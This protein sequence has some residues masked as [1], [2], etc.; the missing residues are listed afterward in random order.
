MIYKDRKRYL[1]NGYVVVEYPEHE[2]A[3]DTGTGFFGV[4]EHILVAEIILLGRS[5]VKG[6]VVHHLD[7]NRSNNSPDNLLVLSNSMHGK[8]HQWMNNYTIEPTPKQ[9]ERIKLG[10][11]RCFTC[12]FPISGYLVYCSVKCG[13]DR[14]GTRCGMDR[15]AARKVERPDKETLEKLLWEKPTTTLAKEFGVSDKAVEKWSKKYG[16]EKPPRGHWA[17]QIP[18]PKNLFK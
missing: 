15:L 3:F 7:S 12:Q 2:N 11:V 5:T 14:L 17:K 8:L 6:E 13:M 10:C 18:N 4:Y 9:Q 16:I 1:K